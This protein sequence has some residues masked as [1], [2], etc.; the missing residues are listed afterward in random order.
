MSF[1]LKEE[2]GIA[3]AIDQLMDDEIGNALEIPYAVSC[4]LVIVGDIYVKSTI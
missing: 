3:L 2:V 4:P 1:K